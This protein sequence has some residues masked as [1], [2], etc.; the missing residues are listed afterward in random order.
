MHPELSDEEREQAAK[1]AI[2]DA[3]VGDESSKSSTSIK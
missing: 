2:N 1:A 3:F